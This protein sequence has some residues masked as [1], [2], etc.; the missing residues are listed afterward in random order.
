MFKKILKWTIYAGVVGLL[1][2]GAVIRTEAKAGQENSQPEMRLESGRSN[3]QGEGGGGA[4]RSNEGGEGAG[5]N[6]SSSAS[7][8]QHLL[9][10]D[11]DHEWINLSGIVTGL[12]SKSLWI[13][14]P[15]DELLEI[16]G[17]ILR[18]YRESG[19]LLSVG[20]QVKLEGFFENEEF[21]VSEIQNLTTSDV[22][23]VRAENGRPLWSGGA[24]Q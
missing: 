15:E 1:I 21:K 7:R 19:F 20:D 13:E 8:E 6:D 22:L 5:R 14:T 4:G 23:Q 12:D 3:T 16:S 24:G 18:F 9:A 17:R 2:F 11:E 10:E